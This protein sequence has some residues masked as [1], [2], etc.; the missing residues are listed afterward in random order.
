MTAYI[1]KPRIKT[2]DGT[3]LEC[4]HRHD[5]QCHTDTLNGEFYMVDGGGYYMRQSLNEVPAEDLTITSDEPFEV[6]REHFTWGRNYDKDM[7]RLPETEW[8]AL[9]D[10]VTEHIEAILDGNWAK[11]Y[12]KEIMTRELE[13]RKCK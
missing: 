5:Y 10:L 7:N 4:K 6:I 12:S 1:I 2:P 8:V 9:K 11:G 3:I 13:Y